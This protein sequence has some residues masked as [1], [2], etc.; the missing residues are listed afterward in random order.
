MKRAWI[1]G[2]WAVIAVVIGYELFGGSGGAFASSPEKI[3]KADIYSVTL[4]GDATPET[5]LAAARE[6]CAKLSWC[7]V[8][9]WRDGAARA[10][11]M[12]MVDREAN[13]VAFNYM[14][15]RETGLDEA[16]WDCANWPPAPATCKAQRAK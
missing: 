6:H 9:G 11:A 12:P 7:K 10:K 1:F 16:T 4:G 8:I 15:N 13:T 3:A 2:G 14:L 5:A